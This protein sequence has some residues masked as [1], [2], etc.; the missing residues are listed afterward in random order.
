MQEFL[1]DRMRVTARLSR[2][3][4]E[5]WVSPQDLK[6]RV[7][8]HNL[9]GTPA[10]KRRVEATLTLS[11]AFP[12]FARYPDYHF[13]DPQ[14]AKEGY[15]DKLPDGVTDERGE[16]ELELGL[17]RYARATYRLHVLARAFELEGGRSVAA[18]AA[19]LVSELPF[20]VGFKA[21]GAL[22]YVSRGAARTITLIAI[23]PR[24]K[25]TAVE[26]L[27]LQLIERTFVSVLTRQPNGTY[28]YES[29]K[30]EVAI[31]ERPLAITAEG[32]G[33]PLATDR[34]GTF[35]YVVRDRQGVELNRIEY[36]VA[37]QGNVARSLERN[38]ELE[39]RLDRKDYAP[40]DEISVSIRAPY[41]GAGLISIERDRVYAHRWF[42]TTT[43]ATVQRIRL[44]RD[45]EGNGYVSVQFIRDPASDEIFMSPLSYGV[46]PFM[47]SLAQ[48]TNA[49]TLTAPE[50]ARPGQTVRFGLTAAQPARAVVF[51]VDEGI[52][53]VARY[54]G[55]D[56]L[57]HFFRKRALEVKTSQILDLIL[58][59]FAKLMQAAAPGGDLESQLGRHL[60]PFKRRRDKP[61]VFWSGI[62]DVNGSREFTYEV[63][64]S[65]NG[66]LRVLAVA[67]ND[68]TVGV[69]QTTSLVRGDFVL[70]PNVPV[71]LAPGDE[72][73][74]SV[75]VGNNVRGSGAD[76]TVT[77]SLATTPHLAVIGP[78]VQPLKVG[79]M[80]EGV[81][82]FRLRAKDGA[83]ARLGSATLTFGADLGPH[84]PHRRQLHRLRRGAGREN[85]LPRA[86]VRGGRG[87][88][89]PARPGLGAQQLSGELPAPL[90]RAA[91][92][93]GDPVGR[94]RRATRVRAHAREGRAGSEDARGRARRAAH[95]PERRG[96]VRDVDGVRPG[97]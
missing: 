74:V 20:L 68:G 31:A 12:A 94:A 69:A 33:L 15:R 14:R 77:V 46:V 86:S 50:L 91:R 92:Q 42:K 4:P 63:P 78:A 39:L 67:V 71:A 7:T 97:R 56:P 23:D 96:R 13:Y 53:Q 79:E 80:R 89:G 54:A 70:S 17:E 38:A 55:P 10:E 83:E 87:L 82:L 65:F 64:A 73:D 9:F 18:E 62:V 59:E 95:A 40:G 61:V 5:G 72:F 34:P 36:S 52:L 81:A 76:A 51:A 32:V 11:P 44:P 16:V 35:A 29:R 1:P 41:T 22:D 88:S 66:S 75:G 85:P 26:T 58:P 6:A 27:A 37:G 93:P 48:R 30:R 8:V 24:G 57:G 43:L 19:T 3:A 2:E 60:N 45:F 90:H 47:T 49:L 28:K 25:K 21:D 84:A